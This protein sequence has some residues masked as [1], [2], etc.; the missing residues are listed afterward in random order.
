MIKLPYLQP[1][2]PQKTTVHQ[3]TGLDRRERIPE[4]AARD[5]QN[6]SAGHLP[7]LTVRERRQRIGRARDIKMLVYKNGR[8]I[9][10]ADNLLYVD[11]KIVE[12][13]FA[14]DT[15]ATI[16]DRV[17][18]FPEKIAYN[19]A[20]GKVERLGAKQTAR[21][22][23]FTNSTLT[24]DTKAVFKKGDGVT[25]TG[26]TQHPYNNRTV[27]IQEVEGKRLTVYD[28]V[29]QHGELGSHQPGSWTE[30]NITLERVVPDL[31][32]VCE[33][34][35][36]LWGTHGN[37][38]CCCKL[39]DPTNWNV[40]NGLSTDAWEVQVGSDG[41]FT[42]IAAFSSHII[43]FK[44]HICHKVYGQKPS[45]MQ[46]QVA[47]ID[48]V[49]PGCEKSIVNINENIFYLS[50]AGV[51]VY[52]GGIPDCIS[53][54]L[55][56]T[57]TDAAAGRLDSK[58]YLSARRQDGAREL[59]VFDTTKN[60]WVKEDDTEAVC[61]ASHAGALYWA[62][63]GEIWT[64]STAEKGEA[65]KRVPWSVTFGD[66]TRMTADRKIISRLHVL[67]EL[68]KESRLLCELS[69]DGGAFFPAA[70]IQDTA[71]ARVFRIPCIP[72][73]CERFSVRLSGVGQAVIKGIEIKW[74]EGSDH[75]WH[76]T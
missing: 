70:R 25:I 55:T 67:V 33:K 47:H 19:T 76:S 44:E 1:S 46:V 32:F 16:G 21:T 60:L 39:G 13:C 57:Y 62:T 59:L 37:A 65:E 10:V 8:Q 63:W 15:F 35:N 48:G 31:E 23:V 54:Q 58:Y 22:A 41:A 45:A 36:R 14:C 27:V 68:P 28:N 72:R 6:L 73:R 11:G 64:T 7:C 5:M 12:R 34:D 24:L 52:A 66:F 42:G 56:D 30:A 20:T 51:M 75:T 69:Y 43:A 50:H 40:F 71:A 18:I 53:P 38:I 3:F 26:C 29:F 2:A 49:K 9:Y 17:C 74:T 4:G 61:F